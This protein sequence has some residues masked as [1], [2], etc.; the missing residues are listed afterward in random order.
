[1]LGLYVG[2]VVI[3]ESMIGYLQPENEQTLALVVSDDDGKP[4]RRVLST[5]RHNEKLYVAANHWP[6]AW[7]NAL[8]INPAVTVTVDDNTFSAQAVVVA[9]AS[10][11][12]DLETARP[13]GLVFRILTGF[14][15][16]HFVRLEPV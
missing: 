16:R 15:P 2:V 13:L 11:L 8:K 10:E 6:R 3:F 1:M 5:I 9:D 7:F 14:P 4:H 12:T